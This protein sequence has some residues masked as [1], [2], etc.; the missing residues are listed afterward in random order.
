[1]AEPEDLILDGAYM[2]SRLARDAW[3][4]YAPAARERVVRLIDVRGRLELFLNALFERPI[5]VALAE[6]PAPVSWLA[7]AAGRGGDAS[8]GAIPGTDGVRIFLP[9]SLDALR[10]F[11]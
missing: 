10:G 4:R 3:R 1:M 7:R 8:A 2:A 6:P 5:G 11:E 9:S